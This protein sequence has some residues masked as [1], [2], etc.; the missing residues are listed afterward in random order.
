MWVLAYDAFVERRAVEITSIHLRSRPH[1]LRRTTLATRLL[2]FAALRTNLLGCRLAL[3]GRQR[4]WRGRGNGAPRTRRLRRAKVP[5]HHRPTTML[6]ALRTRVGATAPR[7][8]DTH[9][10]AQHHNDCGGRMRA[11]TINPFSVHFAS[12]ARSGFSR[13]SVRTTSSQSSGRGCSDTVTCP[14]RT[15]R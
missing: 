14:S 11:T 12:I 4:W 7:L 5:R 2:L 3:R 10:C 15:T 13:M 1:L 8:V 9:A 6:V